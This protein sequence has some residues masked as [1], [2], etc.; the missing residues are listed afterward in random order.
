MTVP[1]GPGSPGHP[2]PADSAA[3]V[4]ALGPATSGPVTTEDRTGPDLQP[5][6]SPGGGS[7]WASAWRRL[8]TDPVAILG[9]AIV[10][11]FVLVALLAPLLASYAPGDLIGR[12]EIRPGFIPGPREGNP[13]GLDSRRRT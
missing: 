2:D 6:Q 7:L 12:A 4:T 9:F 1:P 13:L 10:A 8:R 11:V 3:P 5:A